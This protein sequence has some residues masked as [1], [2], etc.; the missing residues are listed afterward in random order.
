MCT[1]REEDVNYY[2]R[3]SENVCH[4]SPKVALT[5]EGDLHEGWKDTEGSSGRKR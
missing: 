4:V 2:D 5:I 1:R 3:E